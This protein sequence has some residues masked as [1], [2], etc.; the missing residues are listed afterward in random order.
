MVKSQF[1]FYVIQFNTLKCI[2]NSKMDF[3]KI[4][5]ILSK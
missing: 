1:K 3:N 5:E 4:K 2:P